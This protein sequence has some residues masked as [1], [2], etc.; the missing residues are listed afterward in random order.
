MRFYPQHIVIHKGDTITFVNLDPMEPHTVTYG[1]TPA[2]GDFA[3]SGNPK[4]FD[5]SKPLNSGFLGTDPHW[6]GTTYQ[7]K[8]VKAGTFAFRCDLHDDLGM[9]ATIVVQS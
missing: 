8:F 2:S 6:F 7:V 1:P 3:P 5:G 4:A 9:L